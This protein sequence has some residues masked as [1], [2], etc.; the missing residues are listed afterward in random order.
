MKYEL[1]HKCTYRDEMDVIARTSF[2]DEN[3]SLQKGVLKCNLLVKN[4]NSLQ[5]YFLATE[6]VSSQQKIGFTN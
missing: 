2:F 6:Y 3:F 4:T 1:S 5:K